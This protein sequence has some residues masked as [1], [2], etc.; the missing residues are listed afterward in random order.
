MI[1][2][3]PRHSILNINISLDQEEYWCSLEINCKVII[4]GHMIIEFKK[5]FLMIIR[6]LHKVLTHKKQDITGTPFSTLST[7]R[8]QLSVERLFLEQAR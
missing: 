8:I 1:F 7:S 3:W 6:F 5:S 2:T 4:A